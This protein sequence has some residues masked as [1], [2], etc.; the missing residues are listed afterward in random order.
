MKKIS[1][2][3]WLFVLALLVIHGVSIIQ[4]E[5]QRKT[6]HDYGETVEVKIEDLNCQKG[7]MAFHFEKSRFE[8]KIDARTCVLLNEGQRIK[9]KHS[10]EYPETF[11]FV[12]ERSPSR[13][14]LGGLEIALG[15]I[16]LLAN[17]PLAPIRK[18]NRNFYRLSDN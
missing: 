6:I 8:K 10:H 7:M 11:L 4:N 12:N 13:F 3:F 1:N 16:G 5:W 17:W 9:L 18:S 2:Y 14:V 15:I